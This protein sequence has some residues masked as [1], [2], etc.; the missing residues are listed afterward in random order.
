MPRHFFNARTAHESWS[1]SASPHTSAAR[2]RTSGQAMVEMA[3]VLA[4]LLLLI[5]GGLDGLQIL[6][7]Q[8]TVNQAVRASAHQAALIGGPDGSNGSLQTSGT[9]ATGTVA[10]TARTILN[11][12]MV[13]SANNA[14]ITVTCARN[15]C[16]RYDAITVRITYQAAIWAPIGP[17]KLVYADL[18]ATRLAEKDRQ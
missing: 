17:F 8:Y 7:T 12:G 2:R 10:E 16:R 9:H 15:P 3:L 1:G 18:R 11:S 5:L 6:M 14:T 4:I 13:T